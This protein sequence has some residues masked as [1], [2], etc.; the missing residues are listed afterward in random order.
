MSKLLVAAIFISIFSV[1]QI[2]SNEIENKTPFCMEKDTQT[3]PEFR[4]DEKSMEV[5]AYKAIR[6]T[7]IG[8]IFL[9]HSGILSLICVP[10]S[11]NFALTVFPLGLFNAVFFS[12]IPLGFMIPGIIMLS[13]G[14]KLYQ[15]RQQYCSSEKLAEYYKSRI[16]LWQTLAL[17]FGIVTG[18]GLTIAGAGGGIIGAACFNENNKDLL[19][20][21]II[22]ISFGSSALF[23]L[24]IMITSLAMSAWLKGEMNRLSVDIG[25]TSGNKG[26]L[27][28][29]R[30]RRQQATPNGATI[31]LCVK[32]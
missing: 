22:L 18:V 15:K 7:A 20:L 5:K 1:I 13:T 23:T 24:P 10:L 17:I 16:K 8:S 11:I 14:V 3:Q 26:E 31:A 4:L 27:S 6:R 29:G 2:Y 25:L 12:V 32:F 28:C 21:G 9:A 19:T 30:S